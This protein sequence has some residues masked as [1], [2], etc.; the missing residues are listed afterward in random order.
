MNQHNGRFRN[1]ALLAGVAL[2]S[3]G[4]AEASMGID[5]GD[6]DQDGD[7]DIVIANQTTE[8]TT[9]YVNNGSG[10]F[11]DWG[12]RSGLRQASLPYTGFGA[13]WVDFDNDGWLDLLTVNGEVRRDRSQAGAGAPN[14]YF[15]HPQ[16]FRNTG[17]GRFEDVTAQAGAALASLQV[18]RG[19]AFG[20]IDNDGDVDV[21]VGN[22][23]GPLQLFINEIGNRNHWLGLRL[24]GATAPR[25][26][27]GARIAVVRKAGATLWRRSRADGSY[28]SAND[29]RVLVGL[30]ASTDVS[31]V[32]VTWP[33]G[34]TERFVSVN[35][36][37]Y[38]VLKEGTGQ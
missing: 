17:K 31:H 14:P 11:E 30:G 36:D 18:G 4:K 2:N 27:L 34:R 35:V 24:I 22:N 29:P 25:D 19:A 23:N 26:M 38:N 15:Q 16:L 12:A 13:A 20:D 8:G 9:L 37:R 7:E 1:Q 33:S 6:F 28:A 3:A 10:V 32:E 21:V 5:A